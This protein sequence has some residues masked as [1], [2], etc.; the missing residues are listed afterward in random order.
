VRH[1]R[2]LFYGGTT[3]GL[4]DGQLLARYATARD[5]AAF[6]AL[7]AQHGPMVLSTCRAILRHEA[8]VEDAFQA[9]FLVLAMKAPSVRGGDALGG[10][11]HRVAY[12]AT[13]RVS[14]ESRRR[15]RH[16]T[17]IAAMTP[18]EVAPA[19]LEPTSPGLCTGCSTGCRIASG[20]RWSSA[21][22]RD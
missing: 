9:T 17:E 10:W 1:L 20:C 4:T 2:D 11:L 18:T 19:G 16:E 7:V 13:V 14:V 5:E 15:R 8:D 22:W 3:I 12:R 21:T 6:A